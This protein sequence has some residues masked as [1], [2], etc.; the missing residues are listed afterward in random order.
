GIDQVGVSEGG[1]RHVRGRTLR[2]RAES[3]LAGQYRGRNLRRVDRHEVGTENCS[4]RYA[5]AGPHDGPVVEIWQ[6]ECQAA[7]AAKVGAEKGEEGLVLSNGEQLPTRHRPALGRKTPGEGN[8]LAEVR[9]VRITP[10]GSIPRWENPLQCD[11]I[12]HREGR[13]LVVER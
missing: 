1:D 5:G 8:D 4:D 6:R 12:G 13:L 7:V 3:Q 2:D 10:A 11:E 9:Y